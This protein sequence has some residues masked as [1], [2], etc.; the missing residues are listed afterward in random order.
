MFLFSAD[1]KGGDRAARLEDGGED[2]RIVLSPG[3]SSLPQLHMDHRHPPGG[4]ETANQSSMNSPP[5]KFH[6]LIVYM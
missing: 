1:A 4:L 5:Y 3:A 6:K 2:Y